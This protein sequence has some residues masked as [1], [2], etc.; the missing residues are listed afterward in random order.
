MKVFTSYTNATKLLKHAT[1][2]L[3]RIVNG[4]HKIGPKYKVS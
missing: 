2:E 1:Q 4:I 3:L